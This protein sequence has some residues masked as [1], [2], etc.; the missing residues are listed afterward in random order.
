MHYRLLSVKP[1]K[2]KTLLLVFQNGVEKIYNVRSLYSE[3]PQMKIFEDNQE[4]FEQVQIDV[5][6]NG[7]IWND[8]LDLDASGLWEDGIETGNIYDV[9][10]TSTLGYNLS[11]ARNTCNM[12]QRDL[13]ELSGIKQ[14]DISDIERGKANPTIKTLKRLADAMNMQLKIVFIPKE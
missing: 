6:E 11:K 2:D 12:F 5:G 10:I 4:L 3:Y 7:I 13:A 14:S 8:E 1:Q 9:D